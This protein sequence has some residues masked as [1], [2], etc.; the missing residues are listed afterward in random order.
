MKAVVCGSKWCK[1]GWE[2]IK[3]KKQSKIR[4]NSEWLQLFVWH[5]VDVTN[6]KHSVPVSHNLKKC[7]GI[8]RTVV[9]SKKFEAQYSL[10]V[11]FKKIY[12]HKQSYKVMPRVLKKERTKFAWK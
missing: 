10:I 11:G 12:L 2:N 6:F 8:K 4:I 1:Q 7:T 9:I 5:W 3:K